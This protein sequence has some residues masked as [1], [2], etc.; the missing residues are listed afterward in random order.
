MLQYFWYFSKISTC[1]SGQVSCKS[2]CPEAKIYSSPMSGW[3]LRYSLQQATHQRWIWVIHCSRP[4]LYRIPA[5]RVVGTRPKRSAGVA[6]EVNLSNPLLQTIT[7]QDPGKAGGWHSTQE[8][9]R[10]RTRGESEESIAPDHHCTGPQPP[11]MHPHYTCPLCQSRPPTTT[12]HAP[13]H[14][15]PYNACPPTTTTHTLTPAT[16]HEM[17][18]MSGQYAFYWNAFLFTVKYG[19]WPSGRLAFNWYAFL[20]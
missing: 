3:V 10:C 1:P 20:L 14:A 7:V 4:S 13:R 19:L 5:K 6:P 12:T 8:V 16:C 11:T 18:S 9:S 15:R 17:R 2:T